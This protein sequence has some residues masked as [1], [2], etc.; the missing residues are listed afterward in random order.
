[1]AETAFPSD[2]LWGA[3]TSA[4]QVEGS[5]LADGAGPS[6]WH[7]FAHA[8]GKIAG[9]DHGDVACDHFRRFADDVALM[10]ELGIGAYRFSISWS[11]VLPA[12]TGRVNRA[13][14]DFYSRLVDTLLEHNIRPFA[15]LYHWDLPAA[16]EDR[17]GWAHADAPHWFAD[18][19]QLMFRALGDRVP[20]W[21]TINE[22]WVITECGYVSGQHAPGRRDWAEAAAVGQN[23]LRAHA[24]AVAAYRAGWKDQIGLVVNL[25]PIHPASDSDADRQAATRMDTYV[26]RQFLDLAVRGEVPAELPEMFGSDWP[27]INVDELETLHPPID[28][29]GVNYYLRLVVRDDPLAGPARAAIVPPQ[30]RPVTSLGWE[31]YPQGLVEILQWVRDCYGN[32]PLYVT[33][34]GAAFEDLPLPN[35]SVNDSQR[36]EYLK[37][38]LQTAGQALEAG[39]DLRGYF[40]WSLFDNFEWQFGYS[41]RFGIVRVD[42]ATQHRTPKDSARYYAKVIRSGGAAIA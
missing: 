23:L 24:A 31:I 35:G 25:V 4:Y 17:G 19:A 7:R 3:A 1:L 11:R 15:T 37:D 27:A 42:Y 30:G 16:L 41:K 36:V 9:G 29:V 2:F 21:A 10:R 13:G 8:P 28:F 20:M 12:G 26:N 32:L 38:H 39:V 6:I 14:L 5:P 22:P 34:N 40:V 33:E 18:Y